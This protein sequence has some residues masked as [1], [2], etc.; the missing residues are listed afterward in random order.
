MI[1]AGAM[2]G[3]QTVHSREGKVGS[4]AMPVAMFDSVLLNEKDAERGREQGELVM[5]VEE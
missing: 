3:G 2:A 1:V 4:E 5:R